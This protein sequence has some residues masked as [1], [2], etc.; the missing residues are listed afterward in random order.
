MNT[1]LT[2]AELIAQE[3]QRQV[4]KEGY[5]KKHDKQHKDG[6][7][8]KAALCY[9][10]TPLLEPRERN[11]LYPNEWPWEKD[12][13]KPCPN[14][15]VRELVKAGALFQAQIERN[16]H[17]DDFCIYMVDRCENEIDK[18]QSTTP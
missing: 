18:L 12:A 1:K 6:E 14:D 3:R 9:F 4:E 13:W 7:L 17:T 10:M 16:K 8:M 5:S 15:R 2:G 11:G